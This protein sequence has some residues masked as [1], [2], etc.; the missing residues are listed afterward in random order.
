M[1]RL[2][3]T[4]HEGVDPQDEYAVPA[5]VPWLRANMVATIDGAVTDAHSKSGGI[6]GS[7]DRKL[8][9]TLRAMADAVL[10]GARTAR[11]ESYRRAGIPVVVLTRSL[12]LDLTGPLFA[13]ASTDQADVLVLTAFGSR[14]ERRA[15]LLAHADRVGGIQLLEVGPHRDGSDTAGAGPDLASALDALRD[16]GLHHVLCEGGPSL[17][18]ALAADGLVDELC[19]TTSP[20]LVGGSAGRIIAE[21]PALGKV[22]PWE[23]AGLT[24]EEG[25]LFARWRPARPPAPR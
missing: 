11:D 20:L 17:L 24:E 18:A 13:P 14:P 5:R 8:F 23:L 2:L 6:S 25:M 12:E 3:P 1:R 4:P 10:V 16:R 15:A 7:A 19:L 22:Q 21:K 9:R